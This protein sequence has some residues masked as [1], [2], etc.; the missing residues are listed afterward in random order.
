MAYPFV[1]M[2]ACAPATFR[3]VPGLLQRASL[4]VQ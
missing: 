2:M 1:A 4:S 3:P